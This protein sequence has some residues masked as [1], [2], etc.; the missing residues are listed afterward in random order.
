MASKLGDLVSLLSGRNFRTRTFEEEI[1][2]NSF[3]MLKSGVLLIL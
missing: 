3:S 1:A 2:E